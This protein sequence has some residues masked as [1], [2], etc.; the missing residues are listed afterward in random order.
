M[1]GA[2]RRPLVPEQRPQDH[3]RLVEQLATVLEGDA[4]AS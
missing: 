1:P 3:H 2:L 4:G